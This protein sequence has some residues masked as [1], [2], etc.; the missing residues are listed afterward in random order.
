MQLVKT[1]SG[2]TLD[3]ATGQGTLLMRME[4][5]A[6]GVINTM[7]SEDWE[8]KPVFE[9]LK[10]LKDDQYI[11]IACTDGAHFVFA[12]TVG[13]FNETVD[14][15]NAKYREKIVKDR[16]RKIVTIGMLKERYKNDEKSASVFVTREE[17]KLEILN[18]S[19]ENFIPFDERPIVEVFLAARCVDN[20]DAP[21]LTIYVNGA[22]TGTYDYV[23]KKAV[24]EAIPRK[25]K[26]K[27][28]GTGGRPKNDDKG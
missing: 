28:K 19:V 27:R 2:G 1:V 24:G 8:H 23:G 7:R 10:K 15:L 9:L 11:K 22:E 3:F 14:E 16:D 12:D 4:R 17:R 5:V 20:V 26:K 25:P 13:K 18:K 6:N 21:V